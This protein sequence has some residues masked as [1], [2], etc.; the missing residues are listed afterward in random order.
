M[1]GII[2]T[3]RRWIKAVT[4]I[5]FNIGATIC[6]SGHCSNVLIY[7]ISKL[8]ILIG[9]RLTIAICDID[10]DTQICIQWPSGECQI[11]INFMN[12]RDWIVLIEPEVDGCT[13]IDGLMPPGV[14]SCIVTPPTVS[15]DGA[16]GCVVSSDVVGIR[17]TR[18]C[19]T[20]IT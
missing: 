11:N 16:R 19:N 1:A 2:I 15:I 13:D 4:R 3:G 17:T 18:V 5:K 6:S 10:P 20:R 8:N 14:I 12:S 7:L 9:Y